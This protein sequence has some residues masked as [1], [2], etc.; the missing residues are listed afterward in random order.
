[1]YALHVCGPM[2]NNIVLTNLEHSELGYRT[3]L[4]CLGHIMDY[5]CYA[6][7]SFILHL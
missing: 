1:M 3:H 5:K 6:E 4:L 2:H 7:M